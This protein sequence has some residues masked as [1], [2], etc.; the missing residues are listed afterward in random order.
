MY[1]ETNYIFIYLFI[2]LDK[3]LLIYKCTYKYINGVHN[4]W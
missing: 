1:I 4:I 3:D 2:L